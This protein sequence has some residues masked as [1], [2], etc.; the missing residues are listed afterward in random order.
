MTARFALL[1]VI[2]A[3]AYASDLQFD[4]ERA[5]QKVPGINLNGADHVEMVNKLNHRLSGTPG[6][7][8]KSCAKFTVDEITTLQ[9]ALY[10]SREQQLQDIYKSANDNRQLAAHGALAEDLESLEALWAK[11]KAIVDA[12][13]DLHDVTRD[14]KCHEAVMWWVHHIPE[15][16]KEELKSFI[17]LPLL[18]ETSLHAEAE[19]NDKAPA[20]AVKS[21][22]NSYTTATGCGMCHASGFTSENT[23][24]KVWPAELT[25]NATGYGAFPFWDHSGPG[26]S[27]CNRQIE[28]GQK[29]K[30]LYS[31]TLNSEILLHTSCGNMSWVGA[32]GYPENTPC[33]HLFNEKYGAFIYTPTSALSTES[34]GKFCCRTY[35]ANDSNFPGA[36][37]KDWARS[38]YLYSDSSG[39]TLFSGFS[40]DYYNGSVKIYWSTALGVDFWYYEDS[41]GNPVEQ[42]EGC[43]FPGVKTKTTCDDPLPILFYHDYDPTTFVTAS[44]T[45]SDFEL[46]DV[47]KGSLLSTCPAPGGAS[48]RTG[49]PQS[50]YHPVLSF[51]ARLAG[52][53]PKN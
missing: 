33:N 18:A 17:T 47:C 12:H 23:V 21:V 9:K 37:P 42:G 28:T 24:A 49:A 2:A 41:E 43:Y 7:L 13:P 35:D 48:R 39:N 1:L 40:G 36:V 50:R 30:V 3:T 14:G 5:H 16:T 45:S 29:V 20:E 15:A 22:M 53:G 52:V 26:C 11:E 4:V 6:L 27:S 46:P 10:G 19:I 51:P 25:Y 44:Y 38:Q 31:S 34:D 8:T 32:S